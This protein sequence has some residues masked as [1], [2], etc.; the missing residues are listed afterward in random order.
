MVARASGTNDKNTK[1]AAE[2]FVLAAMIVLL[3]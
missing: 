1:L 3:R 2:A